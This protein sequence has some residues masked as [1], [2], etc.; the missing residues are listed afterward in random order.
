VAIRQ[1]ASTGK[2]VDDG[3]PEILNDTPKGSLHVKVY[4]PFQT[5]YVDTAKSLSAVNQTGPF[6]VLPE[7]HKFICLL[8]PC[9]VMIVTQAGEERRI[10]I[11]AGILH[12]RSNKATIMLDV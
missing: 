6:D 12:V 11:A 3:Q 1:D 2:M 5:Y 8:E 9:E 7:H 10:K 4:S